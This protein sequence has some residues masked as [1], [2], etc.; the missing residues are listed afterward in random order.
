MSR[1]IKAVAWG[2]PLRQT[3]LC[4]QPT[5]IHAN[6]NALQAEQMQN[7]LWYHPTAELTF[8]GLANE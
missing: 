7:R 2:E 4:K 1:E 3:A 8:Y 5:Q 6:A